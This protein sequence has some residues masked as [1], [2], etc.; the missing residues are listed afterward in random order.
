MERKC[1]VRTDVAS[2][3]L[4]ACGLLYE[5]TAVI[6]P[7]RACAVLPERRIGEGEIGKSGFRKSADFL[8]V[9]SGSA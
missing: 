5:D 1:I 7:S 4:L 6:S 8:H 3:R 9:R 2:N